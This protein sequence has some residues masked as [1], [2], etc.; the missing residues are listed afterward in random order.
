MNLSGKDR[1]RSSCRICHNNCGVLVRMEGG[2]PINV[3]GDPSNPMSKGKLCSKGMASL[4]YLNHPDRLKYPLRRMEGKGKGKWE[5]ISWDDAL[6]I[7][8]TELTKVKEKYGVLAVI[9]LRGASKGLPD[10]YM[11][12]FANLFGSP[13]F[14][15]RLLTASSP[16]STRQG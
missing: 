6:G 7:V 13:T 8:A 5:R 1:I 15:P 12:R 10:D 14:L 4:E 3:E 2:K 11:A 16:E 9:F